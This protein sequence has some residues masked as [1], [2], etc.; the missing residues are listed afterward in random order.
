MRTPPSTNGNQTLQQD[1]DLVKKS[2]QRFGEAVDDAAKRVAPV[3]IQLPRSEWPHWTCT[4]AL[5][6]CT[7]TRCRAGVIASSIN[8]LDPG[9]AAVQSAVGAVADAATHAATSAAK[10]EET[11]KEL[12]SASETLASRISQSLD[13]VK[14][15]SSVLSHQA[16]D[17]MKTASDLAGK[18]TGTLTYPA[19]SLLSHVSKTLAE[20][21]GPDGELAQLLGR[22]S[23]SMNTTAGMLPTKPSR[24]P[25]GGLP[26]IPFVPVP[27]PNGDRETLQRPVDDASWFLGWSSDVMEKVGGQ[28]AALVEGAN[29]SLA[30]TRR[31]AEVVS[32]APSVAETLGG[33]AQAMVD[34]ASNLVKQVA[35]IQS[36]VNLMSASPLVPSVQHRRV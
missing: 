36:G 18:V 22:V 2:L 29:D 5:G 26:G 11:A 25:T 16:G 35:L 12:Q 31:I 8:H 28:V 14:N 7:S 24:V 30:A 6:I 23:E 13:L 33:Q 3:P 9:V 1:Y 27:Y 10:S 34:T 32:S 15:T 4:R 17:L 20:V 21:A 19:D